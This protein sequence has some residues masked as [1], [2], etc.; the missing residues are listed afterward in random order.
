MQE[1]INVSQSHLRDRRYR[2]LSTFHS[3]ILAIISNY[4]AWWPFINAAHLSSY[5]SLTS[6]TYHARSLG[7]RTG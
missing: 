7:C 1:I 4:P 5:F 6:A 3:H 2:H